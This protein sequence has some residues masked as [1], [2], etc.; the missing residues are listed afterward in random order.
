MNACLQCLLPIKELRDHFLKQD[1]LEYEKLGERRLNDFSYC[2]NFS[3][4][5]YSVFSKSSQE[6]D[7]VI[8]PELKRLVRRRFEPMAQHDSHEFMIYLLEA[9]QDEQTPLKGMKFDGTDPKK[10]LEIVCRE[11][12]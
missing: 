4:F 7:W 12:Y 3:K 8:R 5:Y 6:K 11:Y 9:I 10:P 1:Y 2:N